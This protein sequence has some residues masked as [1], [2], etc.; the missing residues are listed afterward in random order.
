MSGNAT[1]RHT[2]RTCCPRR[3][4]SAWFSLSFPISTSG[5]W[6]RLPTLARIPADRLAC[7]GHDWPGADEDKLHACAQVWRTFADSVNQARDQGSSAADAVA[8]ANSGDAVDGFEKER[9][10]V[11]RQWRQRGPLLPRRRGDGRGH[12]GGLR[13][14]GHRCAP[15]SPRAAAFRP[16]RPVP[17]R[18]CRTVRAEPANSRPA[19]PVSADLS[20]QRKPLTR[21]STSATGRRRRLRAVPRPGRTPGRPGA[22][23]A[24]SSATAP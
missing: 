14:G 1:G 21:I 22:A 18:P 23:A 19:L 24:T 15:G 3:L 7:L 2:A 5:R 16:S 20:R 13:R 11:R 4:N 12:R 17:Q 8:S 9:G 10:R 6:Q